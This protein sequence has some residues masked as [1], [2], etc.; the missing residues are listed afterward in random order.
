[1]PLNT[2]FQREIIIPEKGT[3][4]LLGPRMVGKT[5]VLEKE[6]YSI[7]YNLLNPVQELEL[8]AKPEILL[9]KISQLSPGE[10]V[11]IDEIQR[12]PELLNVV[13]IGIDKYQLDFILSGSSARK[14]RRGRANLLGGRALVRNLYPLTMNE[15][16]SHFD[17]NKVLKIGSLPKIMTESRENLTTAH[18]YLD[19]YVTTYIR[20]EIQAEAIVRNLGAF[21][22]FL[23]IAA[24]SNGQ[25][26][27]FS[28]IA[29]ESSTPGSTVKEYYQIMEDT[30]LG[31]FLWPY[32]RKER[33][34]ARPK[35]YFFDTGVT[36]ALQGKLST[37][38]T[39]E[40]RGI[41]FETWFINELVR[42]NEYLRKRLEFSFW[43]ERNHEIDIFIS[44][45][46]KAIAGVEIKSGSGTILPAT[47][48]TVSG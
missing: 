31:F 21:Q 33:K 6:S 39:P 5:T 41:L 16:E 18:D 44:Q 38:I 32:N 37:E 19:S 30:L 45:G 17:L 25:T 7:S 15:M 29:R 2:Y 9:N 12:V 46:G 42:I 26:I 11:F 8:R 40:E 1:M 35:F 34:K 20:E 22:R 14:L 47:K 48:K 43:R 4:L 27:E 28:N 10:R 36:R 3:L 24:Q 13:Q 23:P